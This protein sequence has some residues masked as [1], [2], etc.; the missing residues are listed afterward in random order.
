MG[1]PS[2]HGPSV[3]TSEGSRAAPK[4][5]QHEG[6]IPVVERIL[7]FLSRAS[8]AELV[9]RSAACACRTPITTGDEPS[10]STWITTTARGRQ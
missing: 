6:Q 5:A 9:Q 1:Q 8:G 4:R 3:I 7:H 2:L 10:P